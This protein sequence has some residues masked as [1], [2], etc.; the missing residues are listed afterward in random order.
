[1]SKSDDLVGGT[2]PNSAAR[3]KSFVERIEKLEEEKAAI[4]GDIKDI[5]TEAKSIGYDT[6]TLRRVIR[7][8][9]KD[10]A[11]REE[12]ESLFDTYW[13]ALAD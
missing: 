13:A 1:M 10:S 4:A 8:R 9:K 7:E 6:A 12:Q 2:G 3:L 5:Y 11:D